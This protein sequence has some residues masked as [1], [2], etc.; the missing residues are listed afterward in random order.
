MRK[1]KM[2]LATARWI[3]DKA[4]NDASVFPVEFEKCEKCGGAF[5]PELGHDCRNVIDINFNE[6]EEEDEEA[7]GS[8]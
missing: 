7:E 5:L 3:A 6:V 8:I 2:D 1:I 4:Q